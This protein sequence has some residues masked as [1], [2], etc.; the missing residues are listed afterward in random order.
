[1]LC[2][3]PDQAAEL[4]KYLTQGHLVLPDVLSLPRPA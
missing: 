1:M 4:A 3:H 2:R